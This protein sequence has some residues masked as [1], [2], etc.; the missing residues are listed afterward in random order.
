MGATTALGN[1]V[2]GPIPG[3]GPAPIGNMNTILRISDAIFEPLAARQIVESRRAGVIAAQNDV[4]LEVS[5][6]Y[7]DLQRAAGRLMVS[8][9]AAAHAQTLAEL[10]SAYARSGAGLE[11]DYRRSLTEL[12]SRRR[13]IAAN[14]G[15]LEYASAS[16]IRLIRL[17]PR[18]VVAPVEPPEARLRLIDSN[19]SLDDLV[20]TGLRNRPELSEAQAIVEATLLR[21][22]QARLR[23]FVPSLALRYSAG[24]FGGGSNSYFGA[25]DGRQ[26]ADVNLFW[27]LKGLGLADRAIARQKAAQQRIA[28]LEMVK[29]QDRVAMEVVQAE[30]VRIAADRQV[31]E[32]AA[33][34]PEAISS[35]NL[36]LSS[37]RQGAGLPALSDPSRFSSPSTPWPMP[38]TNTWTPC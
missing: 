38:A 33:A 4:L 3:G 17:D 14:V 8:R 30:K 7:L 36:N 11:A 9:E 1:G 19:C 27:E 21:L 15:D 26:D 31:L 32:A 12:E 28:S 37:I 22:K 5:E 13:E 6:A 35:L 16:L 34:V 25:F 10:T 29:L 23:P 20:V 24:G 2:T 18:I